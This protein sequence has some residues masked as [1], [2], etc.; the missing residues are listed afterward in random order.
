[1]NL[2]D[3]SP[4]GFGGLALVFGVGLSFGA[5]IANH[6]SDFILGSL[7]SAIRTRTLLKTL[8]NAGCSE[9]QIDD[10]LPRIIEPHRF[11]W[12]CYKTCV[13][14]ATMGYV[15]AAEPPS[16]PPMPPEMP[17]Q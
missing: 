3:L 2:V 14:C 1:M 6:T 4:L 13:V 5:R 10:H 11:M 15:P 16:P 17:P 8:R 12:R 9:Q 7:N